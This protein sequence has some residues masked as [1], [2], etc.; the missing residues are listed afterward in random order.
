MKWTLCMVPAVAL[1]LCTPTMAA[2]ADTAPTT[3]AVESPTTMPDGP[4]KTE[5]QQL[6]YA[7]GLEVGNFLK[8]L[9]TEIDI[10]TLMLAVQDTLK[11]NKP[12]LSEEQSTGV[13][14]AFVKRRQAAAELKRT[15]AAEKNRK[16][17]EAFLAKNKQ[18]EGVV[19]TASGLQYMVLKAGT[20]ASPKASDVVKFHYRGTLIDGKEFGT[21]IGGEPIVYSVGRLIP[22]WG[23][24]LQLMKVG[25]KYRLFVPSELGYGE[26]GGGDAIGPNAALIFE[27]EL[28]GIEKPAPAPGGPPGGGR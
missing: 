15:A 13:K 4:L 16:D 6:S 14:N 3:Q 21:S 2:D 19:T 7:L 25:A 17:G 24:A 8:G 11:G 9:E 22:G 12:L 1:L 27:V 28:L 5:T 18:A 20:G 10:E 26:Q 23:E